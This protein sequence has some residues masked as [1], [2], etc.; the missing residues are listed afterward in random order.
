MKI[1]IITQP[2]HTNYGGLLQ[3]YAL[4]QA[5]KRLGHEPITLDQD[6][7]NPSRLRIYLACIKT[8]ILRLL[9]EGKNR[10]Y[11]FYVSNKQK[12]KIR[13]NTDYFINKYILKAPIL[14]TTR[15]FRKYTIDKQLDA[16]IVGSD[17]VWRPIYN[18]N[19]LCSFFDFAK[20]LSVKKIAYAASFG[21]DYWEFNR[22][23]T[24]RAKELI[25]DFCTISVREH[26]GID[27]CRKY[28]GCDAIH[29]LDPT[30]LI[31][32]ED[33]IRLVEKENEPVRKGNLFTYI[34]DESDEKKLII[35]KVASELELTP[36]TSMPIHEVSR[37]SIKTDLESC[38]FPPVTQWLR[39]FM[40]AK[41][42]VCDSFHGAVFSIIFNKPFLI[43][44]NK[45]R[46]MT[47]FNCL[48]D[49]FELHNRMIDNV[50]DVHSLVNT[51]IG[52]ENVNRIREEMKTYS[53]QFLKSN[54][55]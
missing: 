16:L 33:Y 24:E 55:K 46:G 28:L 39:S 13:K 30:M 38:V 31:D 23:Q 10:T 1:G 21:V 2:L 36:F 8:F 26:S 54:L 20:G 40:D 9:G 29:V 14:D 18:R 35:E 37:Y 19:V 4:Q 41:F 6:F 27:L 34:L 53:I 45:E 52:W 32:K 3:N 15:Q 12:S 11:P 42:V 51:P 7:Y 17:Q 44:G 50:A 22:Q 49:T 47:R 5:L 25:R 43:I 48:L